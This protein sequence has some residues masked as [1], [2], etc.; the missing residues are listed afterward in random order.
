LGKI[1]ERSLNMNYINN[2]WKLYAIR[3]FHNLIPAYVIE[4]LFWEEKGMTILM[5]VYA[6]IIYAITVILLEIPSGIIADKWSRKKMIVIDGIL[7]CCELLIL[8][9]ATHFWHFAAAIF[10][11]GIGR[12][13]SSGAENALLYDTLLSHGKEDSYEKCLGRLNACDFTAAVLAALSGSLMAG[14][15][16][17]EFNYWVSVAGVF[18]ST[19][20]SLVLDEPVLKSRTDEH[21][22]IWDYVKESVL[23]FRKH[24]GVCLVLLSGMVA[25]A[26]LNYIDE[27]WQLYISRLGVP[28]IYFGL[29]SAGLSFLRLPG[30]VLAY[31]IR[32]GMSYRS[33]IS[34][35]LL[36]F[37][38]GL[39]YLYAVRGY[40][41]LIVILLICLVSGVIEPLA[42]GYLHHR[43][44]SSMR[45]TIDSFQSLGLR[46]LNVIVGLGFGFFSA[47]YD[48]FGGYGFISFICGVYLICFLLSSKDVVE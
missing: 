10:L 27:F 15:F 20:I 36:V 19:L 8:I 16:G 44:D 45:A 4:R 6:E 46:A 3:F 24:E 7:G 31:K 39:F 5:V 42:S 13:A 38:A 22:A 21:I 33:L 11:A 18:G 25:G 26:A 1:E 23:F 47:R 2:V 30:N 12:A 41:S 40:S 37:A 14:W 9:F 35:I 32:S 43:I 17:F 34:V 28:V 29:F 48:V